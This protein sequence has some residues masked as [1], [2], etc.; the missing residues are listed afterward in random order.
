MYWLA[1]LYYSSE[2]H[3]LHVLYWLPYSSFPFTYA[4][5][6]PVYSINTECAMVPSLGS[7]ATVECFIA[8]EEESRI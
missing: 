4:K 5:K 7:N 3:I 1:I 6:D 2:S 8:G